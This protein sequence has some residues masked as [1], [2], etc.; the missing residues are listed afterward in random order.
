MDFRSRAAFLRYGWSAFR[1]RV[2]RVTKEQR[3]KAD[4]R[5]AADHP[6]GQ[7]QTAED[8]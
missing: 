6:A 1:L 3:N 8:R 4:D 2:K 5:V 7:P